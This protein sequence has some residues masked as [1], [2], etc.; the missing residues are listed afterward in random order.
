VVS[1]TRG[2]KKKTDPFRGMVG[3]H[4]Y[5]QKGRTK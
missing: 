2:S 1:R 3:Q 5:Y 4:I